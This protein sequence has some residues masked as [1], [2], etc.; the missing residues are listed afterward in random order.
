MILDPHSHLTLHR[1]DTDRAHLERERRAHTTWR[2][3]RRRRPPHL[4]S[5]PPGAAADHALLPDDPTRTEQ[6]LL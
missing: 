6:V 5:S 3:R 4:G 1:Q 2:R